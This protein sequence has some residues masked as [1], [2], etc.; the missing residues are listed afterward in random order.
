MER[1][2]YLMYQVFLVIGKLFEQFFFKPPPVIGSYV[3]SLE[4]LPERGRTHRTVPT[5]CKDGLAGSLFR[6]PLPVLPNVIILMRR[7]KHFNQL[8]S[9]LESTEFQ[10]VSQP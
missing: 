3:F 1:T 9:R 5:E 2:W 4:P 8:C 10:A 7:S 6:E